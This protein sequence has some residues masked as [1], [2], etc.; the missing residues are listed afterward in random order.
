M[1]DRS[2]LAAKDGRNGALARV[3]RIFLA[4]WVVIGGS[5]AAVAALNDRVASASGGTTVYS[6]TDKTGTAHYPAT[7]EGTLLGTP[8][9]STTNGA[10]ATCLTGSTANCTHFPN[11]YSVWL[12]LN[13]LT[14]ATNVGIKFF[15]AVVAPGTKSTPN[16]GAPANLSYGPTYHTGGT[17]TEREFEL[18][19]TNNKSVWEPIG[20][21]LAKHAFDKYTQRFQAALFNT[22][23][24]PGGEYQFAVCQVPAN[25]STGTGAPGITHATKTCV[26]S[27]NFTVTGK[28]TATITTAVTA[29]TTTKLGNTWTDTATVTG[30]SVHGAPT[31]TVTFYLC[32]VTKTTG[33][34]GTCTPSSTHKLGTVPLSAATGSNY[35]RTATSPPAKPLAA[36]SWCFSAVYGGNATYNPESDNA[37]ATT[38]APTT[39]PNVECFSV[40]P[41]P[42]PTTTTAT[43]TT[44]TFTLGTAG[45]LTDTATVTGQKGSNAPK[46]TVQFYECF[47]PSPTTTKAS[48]AATSAN[49][50]GTAVTLT[51]KTGSTPPASTAALPSPIPATQAGLYCFSAVYTPG[52][53]T[54]NYTGSSDNT[55]GTGVA[56]ECVKI[57]SLLFTV[58]KT[59]TAGATKPVAP[60]SSLGYTITV[61]NVGTGKGTTK[62]S[63][64]LPSNV[65]YKTGSVACTPTADCKNLT[66]ASTVVSATVTLTGGAHAKITFT[67]VVS[68][69]TT[70]TVTN[71]ASITGPC[72]ASATCSS[73]VH[74]PV[75]SITVHK[76]DTPASGTTVVRG[77][78]ITYTLTAHN[79][80]T[81]TGTDTISDVAPANTNLVAGSAK[82]LPTPA[83]GSCTVLSGTTPLVWSVTVPAGGTVSVSFKVTV[84]ATD[85][86]TVYNHGTYS[87]P[88]CAAVTAEDP[89]S[90]NTVTNPVA[91][92]PPP[93]PP[94]TPKFT[95]TKSDT[96]GTGK[97]V[98]PGATIGYTVL[99]TNVG[100]ASGTAK[101]TDPLPSNVTLSGTPTCKTVASGDS[102]SVKVTGTTL[103]IDVSLAKGDSAKATFDAV[104]KAT[105]TTTVVNTATI[106]TG[107][108]TAP[109]CSST[110][111]NPVVVLSVV[112]SSTPGSGSTVPPLTKVTYTLTLTDSG[113]AATTPV[114]VTDRV[115]VGTTYVA[116][117]ASCGGSPGC[118][119]TEVTGTVTWR[120]IVVQPGVANALAVSFQV[121]VSPTDKNGQT[122]TNIAVF[123]NEGTP[124]CT[125]TTCTTNKV[126]L[127]VLVKSSAPSHSTPPVPVPKAT[128]P[129]TGEPWA[130]SRAL[131]LV[132]LFSGLG[133]LA[134]GETLRRRRRRNLET[135]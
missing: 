93:R 60:G 111:T 115:P 36:G 123:T 116:G 13:K 25:P 69:S 95:V 124:N 96:P 52:T 100:T 101:I 24:N 51:A 12:T 23:T 58:Q 79:A 43:T 98:V 132:I 19:K 91:L 87:G 46:G 16:D 75:P 85:T 5:I 55:T 17:W 14:K 40:T 7:F 38:A 92:P 108:C 73:T 28:A 48:C 80:G 103:V 22:T 88:G 57:T 99:V 128:T 49:K 78:T 126:T 90:T 117:S 120:G 134:F 74:N 82:C 32:Q 105:D 56:A 1:A 8:D 6:H 86:T 77:Q 39:G 64:P 20:T 106:T 135:R 62:L 113:T 81:G 107:P 53:G 72:A 50:H 4:S 114:T 9:H 47:T 84:K 29:P 42:A 10:F 45:T 89:C 130:G 11:K 127:H 133:L 59:D 71:T 70:T 66:V 44:G 3:L 104:V 122:I 76:A 83:N 15:F 27:K 129:H 112:K 110:V 94:S 21:T 65:T 131:E 18:V 97:S 67:V 121:I 30:N 63:D 68:A 102:C 26:K 31:G 41:V 109:H 118:T 37:T 61:T 125:N 35:T 2:K 34:T 33:K 119:V 54:T